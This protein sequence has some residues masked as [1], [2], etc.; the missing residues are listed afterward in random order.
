MCPKVIDS[1]KNRIVKGEVGWRYEGKE[2]KRSEF[3]DL[4]I[5]LLEEH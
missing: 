4:H 5:F 3:R 1:E 2:T